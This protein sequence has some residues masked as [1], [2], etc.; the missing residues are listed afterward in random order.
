M[1][2]KKEELRNIQSNFQ[3][4]QLTRYRRMCAEEGAEKVEERIAVAEKVLSHF[5]SGGV[6]EAMHED[7]L[8]KKLK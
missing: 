5:C 4:G 7:R 3:F 8:L 2:D 6:L 1:T